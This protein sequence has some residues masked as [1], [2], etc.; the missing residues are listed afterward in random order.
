MKKIV[1]LISL[2]ILTFIN[3]GVN[4]QHGN[5]KNL[6]A[7]TDGIMIM[8]DSGLPDNCLGTPYGWMLVKEEHQAI[9]AVILSAWASGNKL[10]T[11]Y[12]SGRE[13]GKGYCLIDQY[14]PMN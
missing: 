4:Y 6:T 7:V 10:G 9:T 2:G 14:D 3:A 5:I 13:N 12:T 11:V 8:L 1:I